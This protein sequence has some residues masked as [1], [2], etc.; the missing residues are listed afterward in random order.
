MFDPKTDKFPYPEQTDKHYIPITKDDGTIFNKDYPYVNRKKSFLF[1]QF[2]T[3]VMLFFIVFP[4][5][6]I[7]LGLRI[8]G[9]K[10]LRKYKKVIK[11]G[12]VSVSNHVHMWDYI[13]IMNAVKPKK[14]YLLAW[15]KNISGESGSLVR[16]VGGIPI[17]EHDFQATIAYMKDIGN[18]LNSGGW[19]HIYPEGSMWEYYRPIRPFKMGASYFA[20]EFNKPI[21]PMAFSYRKPSWIRRKIFKQIACFTLTIGEPLFKDDSLSRKEQELDL[22][23]RANEAVNSLAG[24]KEEERLYKPIFT[25]DRR[26]DYYTTIYG[27]GYKNSK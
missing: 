7:R 15:A 4:M 16:M 24:I 3:R 5:S 23:K 12:V 6:Y 14:T 8:K 13:S 10:N 2:L 20:C 21:I 11:N 27:V 19:L 18:L 9:K 25:N 26:V 17:P 1:K 22:L